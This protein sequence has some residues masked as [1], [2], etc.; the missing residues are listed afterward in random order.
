MSMNASFLPED[1][2]AKK[3][4][5]RTNFICLV[6]FV[7]VMIGVFLAFMFTNQRYTEVKNRQA[8]INTDYHEAAEEIKLFQELDEQKQEMVHK[9]E[10]VAALVEPV[11]RSNIL[12]EVVNRMPDR[13]SLVGF[14]LE[15]EKLKPIL[16]VRDSDNKKTGS[17]KG[18]E[19]AKT[20]EEAA[21]ENQRVLPPRYRTKM[22]L[23]GVAPT[24]QEVARYL[25]E[26][27][28]CPLL[29][30]VILK[31]SEEKEFDGQILR[32][33]KF[34]MKLAPDADV[35]EL[36]PLVKP[37]NLNDPTSDM[38][39]FISPEQGSQVQAE[40]SRTDEGN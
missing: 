36:N 7:V 18:P 15:S 10:L 24:D 2:L 33:F 35:L 19:R 26:L 8:L 29:T 17:L 30:D 20:K 21:E 12:S 1:Y 28:A 25:A 5:R 32:E 14:T 37:R 16:P 27:N 4:E 6:L 9:A 38:L 31:Y 3:A 40:S 39:R 11:P 23:T 22:T 34:D 13:L